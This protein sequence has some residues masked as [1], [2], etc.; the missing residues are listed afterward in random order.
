[1]ED[2]GILVKG[3]IRLIKM[4]WGFIKGIKL[5]R[6]IVVEIVLHRRGNPDIGKI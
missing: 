3:G 2:F 5:N 6:V 4:L 1:M